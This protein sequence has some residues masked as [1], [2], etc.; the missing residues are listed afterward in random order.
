VAKVTCASAG[1]LLRTELSM[2]GWSA[3]VD[4][5]SSPI[6]TVDGVYQEVS[7]PEG[8]STVTYSFTPPYENAALL[9]GL[10]AM[11]VIVGSLVW[12]RRE[13]DRLASSGG[14]A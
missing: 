11:I 13:R 3:S 8:T 7:V 6:A 2:D 9:I 4:G 10:L 1:T 12:D 5:R 14:V